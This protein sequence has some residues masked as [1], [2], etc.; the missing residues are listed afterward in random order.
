MKS[1]SCICLLV[2][3]S[4]MLLKAFPGY[5]AS[6]TS[7]PGK[8][9]ITISIFNSK[10]KKPEKGVSV[11]VKTSK[12]ENKLV[13]DENGNLQIP[14]TPGEVTFVLEKRGFK[15]MRFT[16]KIEEKQICNNLKL[17]LESDVSPDVFHPLS[18]FLF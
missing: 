13:S 11:I 2:L 17:S 9:P 3:F 4:V 14:Y 6:N 16:K 10:T 7:A 12:G 8:E 18:R 5:T 15:T 1:Y